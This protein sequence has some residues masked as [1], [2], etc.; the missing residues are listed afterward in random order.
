[1]PHNPETAAIPHKIAHGVD[2]RPVRNIRIPEA[3]SL[4]QLKG[5]GGVVPGYKVNT[6]PCL[7]T[8]FSYELVIVA[9]TRVLGETLKAMLITGKDRDNHRHPIVL[10]DK[11]T[12]FCNNPGFV[13]CF[14]A[15]RNSVLTNRTKE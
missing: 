1:V 13:H 14:L 15:G 3:Q 11:G 6:R 8:P 12:D 2:P 9:D 5:L 7:A 10:T 4:Y